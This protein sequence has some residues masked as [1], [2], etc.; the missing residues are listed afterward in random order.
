MVPFI[1]GRS[2]D[3]ETNEIH[4]FFDTE[5]ALNACIKAA[6]SG[7]A[8]IVMCFNAD[9]IG[10][11]VGALLQMVRRVEP[12]FEVLLPL[13]KTSGKGI[14]SMLKKSSLLR[15]VSCMHSE[16]CGLCAKCLKKY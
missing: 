8:G 1:I 5:M 12:K 15:S 14:R 7:M 4:A 13:R 16:N 3:G 11:E 9:D 2:R 6:H 10:I